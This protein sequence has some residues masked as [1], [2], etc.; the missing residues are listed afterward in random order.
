M[1][2]FC[3]LLFCQINLIM[4]SKT[5]NSSLFMFLLLSLCHLSPTDGDDPPMPTSGSKGQIDPGSNTQARTHI[6]EHTHMLALTCKLKHTLTYMYIGT[7]M[8]SYTHT[9][10]YT[11]QHA[12]SCTHIPSHAHAH[13]SMY[14]C[15]H[16]PSYLYSCIHAYIH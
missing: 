16:M 8:H 13:T 6:H 12:H 9:N 10:L 1:G 7:H 11:C 14:S 15:T 5:Q 4:A 3:Q 2:A